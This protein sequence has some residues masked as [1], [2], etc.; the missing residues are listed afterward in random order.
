MTEAHDLLVSRSSL[1]DTRLE[2]SE[3]GPIADGEALLKID[4]FSIT[5]NN[6]TYGVFGDA[7]K[8]WNFFPG[9]EGWGRVPVWGFATVLGSK[10]AGVN[11]GQRVYGYLPMSTHLKVSP[12]RVQPGGFRD[13]AAHRRELPGAYQ[14]YTFTDH[15]PLY[16]PETEPLQ[17]LFRPLFITSFLIDDFLADNDL[18]GAK[19][20]LFSSASAKTSYAAA[21]LLTARG[22]DV[23]GLTS[24]K[25]AR[26]AAQLGVY[27]KI[28][29][30][31]D[32]ATLDA[33]IPTAFVDI[34]GDGDVGARVHNHFRDALKLSLAVGATHWEQGVAGAGLQLPGPKPQFF[35]APDRITKRVGDWGGDAF[36]AKSADAFANFLPVAASSTIVVVGHGLEEAGKVFAAHVAGT[37]YPR[38]GNII[39]LR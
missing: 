4:A 38:D 6:V 26:F 33:H 5:A 24:P 2:K 37:A 14:N 27:K 12:E 39:D 15:D 22:I 18:F 9:P 20:V 16:R 3:I 35:F 23:V 34:A 29:A 19:Q 1:R 28:V 36:S 13:G 32:I 25:N 21:R 11:P 31:P 30:Y 8:Y 17:M 10:V 7:M